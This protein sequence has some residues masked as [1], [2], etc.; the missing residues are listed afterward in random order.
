[1]KPRAVRRTVVLL[2]IIGGLGLSSLARGDDIFDEATF[3]EIACQSPE[4][5]GEECWLLSFSGTEIANLQLDLDFPTELELSEIRYAEGRYLGKGVPNMQ[6]GPERKRLQDLGVEWI[7]P[8]GIDFVY[9]PNTGDFSAVTS[10]PLTT[11]ELKSASEVFGLGP[12]RNLDSQWDVLRP[13]KLF[14]LAPSG[15]GSVG[16]GPVLEPGLT[17]AFLTEDISVAG[18]TL[19][20]A[21]PE[22]AKFRTP[23]QRSIFEVELF[24]PRQNLGPRSSVEFTIHATDSTDNVV[25]SN[26]FTLRGPDEISP[27]GL[28]YRCDFDGDSQCTAEDIDAISD[29]LRNDAL[30]VYSPV[31]GDLS[32]QAGQPITTLE[33]F[34][35]RAIFT[36]ECEGLDGSF[37]VCRPD[38]LFKLSP[39]GLRNHRFGTVAPAGVSARTWADDLV[40]N[41]TFFAGG[42]IEVSSPVIDFNGDGR[43]DAFDRQVYIEEV[44]GTFV[45]DS[46][47]DGQF[48]TG[49]LVTVFK[50]AE[51]ED[52]I[53]DNSTWAEGDWNGD[54]EFD[55]GDLVLAFTIGAFEK[56]RRDAPAVVA[57]PE[58]RSTNVLIMCGGSVLLLWPRR[59]WF[60]SHT[61]KKT[62]FL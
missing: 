4:H 29:A 39:A 52:V 14:K 62:C 3:Q 61:L 55:S 56:G 54:R 43:F 1:M 34:S 33:I 49:D 58:P 10:E 16:F 44:L 21:L 2:T 59:R 45:G 5:Q 40:I 30:L 38:K 19:V 27:Q 22:S 28:Q 12:G 23:H 51:Y 48:D 18:S 57:V 11:L 13:E 50:A 46:N 25:Y 47:L 60:A 6:N 41:G 8:D 35:D 36:P 9:D 26:N 20:G 32:L 17:T 53:A 37:D 31:D 24:D 42:P 15:V 7:Q